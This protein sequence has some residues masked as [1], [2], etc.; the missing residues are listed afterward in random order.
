[1]SITDYEPEIFFDGV[2]CTFALEIIPDYEAAIDKM[3]S[4]L[5]PQ[6]R[7]AMIGMKHNFR[8]NLLNPFFEWLYREGELMC[9]GMLFHTSNLNLTESIIMKNAISVFITF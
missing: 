6:G 8:Y 9:I 2:L 3:F 1:M 7:F 5:K 4:L